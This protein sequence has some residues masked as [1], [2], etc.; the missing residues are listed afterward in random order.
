MKALS[1]S[2]KTACISDSLHRQLNGY[3]LLAGATGV[4]TLALAQPAHAKIVY[5]PANI[6]IAQNGVSIKFD[7][8]HDGVPD[9]GLNNVLVLSSSQWFTTLLVKPLKSVDGIAGKT[10]PEGRDAALALAKG[11]KIG[12]QAHF[13]SDYPMG[14]VM[15]ESDIHGYH[16]GY[17]AFHTAYL[18]LKLLI[19]GKAHFG[20]AR[21]KV[22]PFYQGGFVATLTG[23]A[24]ETIAN[25]PILA[26]ATKGSDETAQ[27]LGTLAAGA[28]KR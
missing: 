3:A 13:G 28:A 19:K 5:T 10:D 18:G 6:A 16:S 22:I 25:K 9:F 20:W 21:V 15:A 27:S 1:P 14:A 26:G 24:Y 2:R 17:W 11:H 7:L 4:A 12:P 23:Y 8:N